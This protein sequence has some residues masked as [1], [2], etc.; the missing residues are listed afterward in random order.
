MSEK[1]NIILV[2]LGVQMM[3]GVFYTTGLLKMT[4]KK[5]T[6]NNNHITNS[7]D[8]PVCEASFTKTVV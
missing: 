4:Q 5:T 2:L 3:T 7:K 1:E 6:R 8:V